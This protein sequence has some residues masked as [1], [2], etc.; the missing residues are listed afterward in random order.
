MS[1]MNLLAAVGLAALA[2]LWIRGEPPTAVQAEGRQVAL[3]QKADLEQMQ[4]QVKKLQELVPDQA[5]VMS[6]LAYHFTNLWF[7]ADQENWPLAD[8]YL[9]ETRSNLKWAVRV[10]PKRKDLEGKETVDIA[11]IALGMDNG[12][13][14]Q[15]KKAI[16]DKDKKAFAKVYRDTLGACYAC[17]KASFKPYLRPQMPKAPEVSVINFDPK[18]TEP[19]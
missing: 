6:H 5:A 4:E 10:K 15:L 11:S 18:A 7:A 14:M 13:F 19:Q 3:D 1:R 17:H 8:F 12:P 16:T 2:A 9:S